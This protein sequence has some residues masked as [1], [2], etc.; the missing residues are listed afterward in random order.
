MDAEDKVRLE[1]DRFPLVNGKLQITPGNTT[2][3]FGILNERVSK[4]AEGLTK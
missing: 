1:G 4:V 3:L 2:H